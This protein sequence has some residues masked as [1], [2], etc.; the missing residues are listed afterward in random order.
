MT[1]EFD[2]VKI[3]SQMFKSQKTDV[4]SGAGE[5]D[6]AVVKIGGKI[7]LLTTDCVHEK[8]DFPPGMLP[9][10]MGHMALAVNLSDIAGSGGRALHFLFNITLDDATLKDEKFEGVFK[11]IKKLADHYD[12]S[13]VGGDID[14]GDELYISG[15]AVGE[16][17]RFVTQSGAKPG[18]KICLTGP[19][20][21]AQLTLEQLL[22]GTDRNETAFPASLYTPQP[23]LEEGMELSS[24]ANAMTD[25]SDS[26]AIS[27][28]LIAEKSGLGM[29]IKKDSLPL[30]RLTP[31][32]D[33]KKALKLFLYSGGDFQL[34]Y[35]SRQC[36]HGFVIGEVVEGD[37]KGVILELEDGK[38]ETVEFKGYTHF[39]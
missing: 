26:L 18:D 7:I 31:Y 30:D 36:T 1:S 13:V 38:K 39:Q 28:N 4:L 33:E 10:E 22:S 14:F 6:C 16:A 2:V 35:T 12:V 23:K 3:A 20:G 11:G 19:L 27:L 37:E 32:V 29:I 21:K 17:E 5:D 25:I 15:F 34:V 24:H 9:E 8:T